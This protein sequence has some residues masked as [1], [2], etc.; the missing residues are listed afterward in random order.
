M[1]LEVF[2]IF[3]QQRGFPNSFDLKFTYYA[4]TS[5][6]TIL[7]NAIAAISVSVHYDSALFFLGYACL[8]RA[9]NL[10][11]KPFFYFRFRPH[12]TLIMIGNGESSLRHP[13]RRC[14]FRTNDWKADKGVIE[15]Q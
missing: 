15:I 11:R 5:R 13:D 2:V 9:G 12:F 8:I 1:P 7:S 4:C 6:T 10:I 14:I 3:T